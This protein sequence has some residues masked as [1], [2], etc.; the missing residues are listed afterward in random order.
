M[1]YKNFF[2]DKGL[3]KEMDLNDNERE[4]LYLSLENDDKTIKHESYI[5][6]MFKNILF[7]IK[8]YKNTLVE[9]KSYE[10]AAIARDLEKI[11]E[12]KTITNTKT[13]EE[14]LQT[15]MDFK[16]NLIFGN[17]GFEKCLAVDKMI[18]NNTKQE[19]NIVVNEL[20]RNCFLTYILSNIVGK[21]NDGVKINIIILNYNGY[22][23][24]MFV[25][26]LQE[27]SEK[28][29]Y[30]PLKKEN[31]KIF[32]HK[33]HNDFR[34]DDNVVKSD[35]FFITSDNNKYR[36]NMNDE[37]DKL[38]FMACFNA[39]KSE[40]LIKLNGYFDYLVANCNEVII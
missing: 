11:V 36:L 1:R 5:T 20:D 16:S 35:L 32:Y 17:Y 23:V 6:E 4:Q 26:N 8:S 30:E 7:K 40:N 12:N 13:F 25:D 28:G 18:V 10:K 19:L 21:L 39:Q 9:Q 15:M 38:H 22:Y 24:D 29:S 31:L 37:I 27:L 3:V 2:G 33:E 14:S 34:F